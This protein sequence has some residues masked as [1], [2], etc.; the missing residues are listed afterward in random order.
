MKT[1]YFHHQKLKRF[2][3]DTLE[4]DSYYTCC[5]TNDFE[6]EFNKIVRGVAL[7][8]YIRWSKYISSH[9]VEY[10]FMIGFLFWNV[11]FNRSKYSKDVEV[12]K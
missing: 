7:P 6:I 5:T 8:L 9:V 3:W 1:T 11:T 2:W 12:I 10:R 4:G